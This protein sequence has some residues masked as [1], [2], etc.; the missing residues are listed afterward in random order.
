VTRAIKRQ[1][2][3]L[4]L[5]GALD[6][7]CGWFDST[8]TIDLA[9]T[10]TS[11]DA[12]PTAINAGVHFRAARQFPFD[13][14]Y[15]RPALDFDATSVRRSGY[16]ESGASPFVLH[17][18]NK[19]NIV[20]SATPWLRVGCRVDLDG[21]GT[22]NLFGDAGLS[23]ISGKDWKTT[24]GFADAPI[25]AAPSPAIST[26]PTSSP[27]SAS[28]STP[29]GPVREPEAA[30]RRQ[31]GFGLSSPKRA[32]PAVTYLFRGLP[33]RAPPTRSSHV[34]RRLFGLGLDRP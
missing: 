20:A 33:T 22:L 21:G 27:A 6:R 34:P 19:D 14:S 23:L 28:A 10:L 4:L 17:V 26:R 1:S 30:I 12:S 16:T 25:S 18:K 2:G 31:R 32:C 3:P 5:A 24:A 9:D 8:R 15:L 13:R 7:R 11:A 29:Q